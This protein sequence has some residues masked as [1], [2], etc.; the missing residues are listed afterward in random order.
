MGR[1]AR[2]AGR[3]GERDTVGLPAE[4]WCGAGRLASGSEQKM[5]AAS[6]ATG[7]AG[8]KSGVPA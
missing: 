7:S 5:G 1:L 4:A 6:K 8:E 2:S 3:V